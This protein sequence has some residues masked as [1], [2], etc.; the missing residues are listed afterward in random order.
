[1]KKVIFGLLACLALTA[2]GSSD[3]TLVVTP[4][5]TT[6]TSTT[7]VT[8]VTLQTSSPQIPSDGS[9]TATITALVRDANNQLVPN[10]TVLFQASSGGLAVTQSVTN[11][12]G[13]AT[14]TLSS[15][16]DYTNRR[17][18]VTATAGG[19]SS[20]VPV[21]VTGTKLTVSGSASLVQGSQSTYTATL[22][23]SSGN[24]ISNTAV[25]VSSTNSN[26]LSASTLTTDATGKVTFQL[27]AANSGNDT[28]T[29]RALGLQAQQ[30]ITVSSQ[31]FVFSSP[32]ANTQI[33]LG[34]NATVTV[35]WTSA[36]VAQANKTISFSSTRGTF[37]SNT[38]TTDSA[39]KATVTIFSTTS[40]PGLIT[41]SGTGV[42][43]QTSVTFIATVP[44]SISIQA[45]PATVPTSGQ[46]TITAIVRD[47]QNNLV[48]GQTVA[49][50]LT[51]VTGGGLSA[52]AVLTDAQGR[53]QTTYTAS[54]T[55]SA[56]NGVIVTA[57]VQ[58]TSVT[59]AST[60]LTVGGQTVFL[61][62]GTGNKIS[63]NTNK[64][65]FIVPFVVQALD[66]AGNAVNGVNV[67]LT[68]HSL[69]YAKGGYLWNGTQWEQDPPTVC[70]SED[71]N[72]NGVLDA[73]E[74]TSGTGNNNGR[75][76]PGDVAATTPGTVTTASNGSADL[77]VIYPE[78]HALWVKARL[79]ATATVQGTQTS[80]SSVFW[81]PMLA[82]YLTS[83]TVF[84]PGYTSPYGVATTCTDPN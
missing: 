44:N 59:P 30:A 23:D 6:T 40:G 34:Q 37:S 82:D 83:Q 18:T 50:Q 57:S 72:V 22:V 9:T 16:G 19:V 73:G 48:Q 80:T 36:G 39:G 45:S 7:S 52:A 64:T 60:A 31:S 43:A 24:G 4:A 12:S 28:I 15:A 35:T 58:G 74:D 76:D 69:Q 26:T 13:V 84:P 14:A 61:S 8:A 51:D 46:S 75:L 25:T 67:T 77:Q 38:A 62:L 20:T 65:Q 47:A 2:C 53:A 5:S 54:S 3:N 11:S 27:T 56:S 1:M 32:A 68:V 41:A 42:T 17:I 66:S 78:D 29:A 21:D 79:T 63:E 71:V 49:F 10:V 55:P 81:L 33:A 70:T